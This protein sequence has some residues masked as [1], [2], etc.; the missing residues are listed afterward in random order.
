M[1]IAS[2]YDAGNWDTLFLQ[3]YKHFRS[4]I[5]IL[6]ESER[7]TKISPSD[8]R[9]S[10]DMKTPHQSGW[11]CSPATTPERFWPHIIGRRHFS[12]Q[13][14]QG[15]GNCDHWSPSLFIYFFIRFQY[16]KNVENLSVYNSYII[17][18]HTPMSESVK[19]TVTFELNH[20]WT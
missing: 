4:C 14:V 8:Q 7:A 1:K 17:C 19:K 15:K 20:A 9:G 18:A 16:K 2:S 13:L 6:K 5:L 3:R 11:L 10:S 12:S